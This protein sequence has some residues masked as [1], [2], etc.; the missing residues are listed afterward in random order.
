MMLLMGNLTDGDD[1]DD[2]DEDVVDDGDDDDDDE[3][4]RGVDESGFSSW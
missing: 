4:A 3:E 2:Y 1:A